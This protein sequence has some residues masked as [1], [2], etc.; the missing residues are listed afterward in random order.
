[1]KIYRDPDTGQFISK[2]EWERIQREQEDDDYDDYPDYDD[3][4]NPEEYTSIGE[5]E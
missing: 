5:G 2:E 3:F 4:G 1:M